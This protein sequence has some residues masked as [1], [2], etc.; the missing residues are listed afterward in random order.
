[1]IKDV[2]FLVNTTPLDQ[3]PVAGSGVDA[4]AWFGSAQQPAKPFLGED[5]AD[6][7]AV[8]RHARAKL[9]RA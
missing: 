6:A 1:M 3:G 8:E 2:P 5:L 7:G 4:G 9:H